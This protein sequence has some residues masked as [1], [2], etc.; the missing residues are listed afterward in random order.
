M[1]TGGRV[2]RCGPDLST[3]RAQSA[4]AHDQHAV[5]GLTFGEEI[6]ASLDHSWISDWEDAHK[7]S[8]ASYPDSS[9]NP[10]L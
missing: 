7:F 6:A 5:T 10:R 1:D 9:G 3:C 2:A 8:F 4:G